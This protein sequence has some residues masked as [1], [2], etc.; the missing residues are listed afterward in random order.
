M[1]REQVLADASTPQ[2]SKDPFFAPIEPGHQ[3]D[4]QIQ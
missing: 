1:G 3:F 2:E 4:Q